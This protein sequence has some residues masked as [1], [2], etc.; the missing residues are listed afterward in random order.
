VDPVWKGLR[1][2]DAQS[3]GEAARNIFKTVVG[4]EFT[5]AARVRAWWN[6]RESRERF[7]R[8]RTGK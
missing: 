8:D 2:A 1:Q 4:V 5:S 3:I 7:L 6:E